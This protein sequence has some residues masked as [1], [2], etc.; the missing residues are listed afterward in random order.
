MGI[1]VPDPAQDMH[2]IS[3]GFFDWRI[4]AAL[5]GRG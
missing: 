1:G 2:A 5:I 4:M 3:L